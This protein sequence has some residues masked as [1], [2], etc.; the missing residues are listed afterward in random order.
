MSALKA[1]VKINLTYLNR[2]RYLQA[3]TQ[4]CLHIHLH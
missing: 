2:L 4:S 1:E 3:F